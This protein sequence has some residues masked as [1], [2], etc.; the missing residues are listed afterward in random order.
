VRDPIVQYDALADA[1][2]QP[3]HVLQRHESLTASLA[4]VDF[5]N[6]VRVKMKL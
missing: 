2:A 6:T 5:G 1:V 3:S 4:Q